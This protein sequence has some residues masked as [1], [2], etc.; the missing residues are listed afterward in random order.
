MRLS[1]VFQVSFVGALMFSPAMAEDLDQVHE[2]AL[3]VLR[4]QATNAPAKPATAPVTAAPATVGD[5]DGQ[6]KQQNADAEIRRQQQQEERRRKF[7]QEVQQ[8]EMLRQQQRQYD[9]NVARQLGVKQPSAQSPDELHSKALEILRT[10]QSATTT[11][12]TAPAPAPALTQPIVQPTPPPAAQAAPRPTAPPATTPAPSE[13]IQERA[14][15]I[16]KQ[17]QAEMQKTPSS[18]QFATPGQTRALTAEPSSD[19]EAMHQRALEILRGGQPQ[20]Q[21][22]TVTIPPRPTPPPSQPATVQ[23]TQSVPA[24]QPSIQPQPAPTVATTT[25]PPTE[26]ANTDVHSRALDILHQQSSSTVQPAV[27]QGT[28]LDPRTQEMIRRQNQELSRQVPS[29][30]LPAA[31]TATVASRP[32]ENLPEHE[33]TPEMESRAREILRQQSTASVQPTPAAAQPAPSTVSPSSASDVQ[34][35]KELEARARQQLL[36][37]AQANQ[38]T[39]PNQ[40]PQPNN[41]TPTSSSTIPPANNTSTTTANPASDAT[42]P[43]FTPKLWMSWNTRKINLRLTAPS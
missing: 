34:Y 2:Q 13:D 17:Q 25:A 21:P 26:T 1:T 5:R 16:L 3:K 14:R 37:R 7:E 41:T 31:S 38:T 8:R 43:R 23:K 9:E 32:P 12:T 27:T 20:P 42:S 39:Q 24:P 4:G 30:S 15:E 19:E 40:T 18:V 33:L 6:R 11:T 29:S 22:T 36:D 35:S 10:G 28:G